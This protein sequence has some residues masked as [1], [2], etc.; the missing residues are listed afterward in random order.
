MPFVVAAGIGTGWHTVHVKY[1]DRRT[2]RAIA[3][4][5]SADIDEINLGSV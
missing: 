5:L 1:A 2:R 4:W 3:T